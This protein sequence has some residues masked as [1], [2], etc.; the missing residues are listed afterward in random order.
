MSLVSTTVAESDAL[1][2]PK[3]TPQTKGSDST[4]SKGAARL[5]TPSW[6]ETRQERSIPPPECRRR[7]KIFARVVPEDVFGRRVLIA[8]RPK[9]EW[10]K[11][12]RCRCQDL[13]TLRL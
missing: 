3:V 4:E 10:P 11:E 13:P 1:H 6:Q 7:A 2:R 8:R 9:A 5:L 12:W